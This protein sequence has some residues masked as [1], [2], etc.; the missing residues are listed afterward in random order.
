M[1]IRDTSPQPLPHDALARI[2]ARLISP[3]ALFDDWLMAETEATLALEAWRAARVTRKRRAH[4]R[5]L[6]A[7][8]REEHAAHLLASRLSPQ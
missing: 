7:L 6:L 5:Y 8:D 3:A 2:G 4:A 1:N